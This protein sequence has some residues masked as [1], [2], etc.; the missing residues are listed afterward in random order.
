MSGVA[1]RSHETLRFVRDLVSYMALEEKLGQLDLLH[2]ADDPALE[3]E[4]AAGRVGGVDGGLHAQRWQTLATER[5]RLGIPLLLTARPAPAPLSPWALAASW[6]EGLARELG[7]CTARA[8]I[9]EGFNAFV[10]PRFAVAKSPLDRSLELAASE[11]HLVARIAGAYCLGAADRGAITVA[12]AHRVPGSSVCPASLILMRAGDPAAIDD[13]GLDPQGA[14]RAG[15]GGILVAECARIREVVARQYATTRARSWLEAAERA[16][17]AGLLGDAEIDRA[18]SGVLAAKHSLGL[19]RDPV[20]LVPG[21]GGDSDTG[22]SDVGGGVVGGATRI[23]GTMV[24]LRNE[25]GLLPLSPVSDRVVV[26]GPPDGAAP[27]CADAVGR[28]GIGHAVAPGLATRRPGES[29]AQPVPGDH[30]ALALTRDAAKRADFVLVML[31]ERHFVDSGPA[32]WR[33]PGPAMMALLRAL[34][35]V[36]SRLVALITTEEPVVLGDADQHFAAVLQCWAPGEGFAG[37]LS[38][39]LSGRASPQGRMPVTAGRYVFG[40]GLGYGET[41]LESYATALRSDHVT[42]SVRVANSGSFAARETVQLFVRS[43]NHEARLAD[44]QHVELAPGEAAAVHFELG[45]E[46]LG[47]LEETGRRALAPGPLDILVGK[48][49][50][51]VLTATVDISPAL[52]RAIVNRDRGFLRLAG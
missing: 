34:A 22:D 23:R 26:V 39:I 32:A 11:P 20:R 36:G 9:T 15:F 17:E 30:F 19:F 21:V 25:A 51:R 45:L 24:L 13:A 52:A 27:L 37:A 33:A 46:A 8:A 7:T 4:I 43:A 40:H 12:Q 18:L 3:Q 2:A 49:N 28:A 48:D 50:R 1:A 44:F 6:D 35:P 41:T 29:W 10:G 16:L 14:E 47:V 42:A 5:S 31:E 38:D